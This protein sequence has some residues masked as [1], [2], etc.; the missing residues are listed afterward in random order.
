MVAGEWQQL[1]VP[2][3]QV[4]V[5]VYIRAPVR[6]VLLL[7]ERQ[8]VDRMLLLFLLMAE[9]RLVL[10]L[11]VQQQVDRMLLLSLL[12]F[13]MAVLLPGEWQ[14]VVLLLFRQVVPVLSVFL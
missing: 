5:Q 12:M 7:S 10:L 9:S 1:S 4:P 11:S 2:D 3:K 8:Q 6:L 13:L 14:M